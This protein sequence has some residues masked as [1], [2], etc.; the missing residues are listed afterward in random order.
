METIILILFVIGFGLGI[1]SLKEITIKNREK[2]I[3]EIE[4][5]G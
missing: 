3:K 2:M 1:Y 5:N 4:E